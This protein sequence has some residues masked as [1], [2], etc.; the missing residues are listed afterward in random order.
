LHVR[1]SRSYDR[2]DLAERISDKLG[3]AAPARWVPDGSPVL[4]SSGASPEQSRPAAAASRA[5]PSVATATMLGV[6]LAIPS[7]PANSPAQPFVAAPASFSD[8]SAA[9]H[10]ACGQCYAAIRPEAKFCSCCGATL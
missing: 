1:W 9:T 3:L 7:A 10:I 6:A 4:G 8:P 2:P 5:A